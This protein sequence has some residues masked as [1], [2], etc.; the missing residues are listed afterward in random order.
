M[1]E[2]LREEMVAYGRLLYAQGLVSGASGNM[3]ARL[4]AHRI[5]V[6]PSGCHKG[7]LTSSDLVVFDMESGRMVSKGSAQPSS[8][9]RMHTYIYAQLPGVQAVIH[10]HPPY[11]VALSVAGVSLEAVVLPETVLALGAIADCGYATPTTNDVVEAIKAPVQSGTSALILARHGS[12][13]LGNS[14][15]EAFC[16]LETLEHLARV[17]SIAGSLGKIDSLTPKEVEKLHKIFA[18]H[19]NS[20]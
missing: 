7:L 6:T 10:A 13:T 5:L 14:L 4:D 2:E 8:E 11:A 16:R 3:S 20:N 12:V 18:Y 17:I 19:Q 9:F 15:H 1:E